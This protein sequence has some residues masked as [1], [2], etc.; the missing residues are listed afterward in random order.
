V[1]KL[2]HMQNKHLG[3]PA[4]VLGG[5]PS[6]LSDM[7]K[8]P[9]GCI[10]FAVNDH[11]FHVGIEPQYMVTMDDPNIKPELKRI[12]DTWRGGLRVNEL[13][14]YSDIDLRGVLRPTARSGI[15]AVWLA[16][17]LGCVPIYLCG[18]DLYQGD[19]KYCHDRDEFMGHKA[20]Y[21]EPLEKL[22]KDWKMLKNYKGW[23][24]IHAVSGPLTQVFTKFVL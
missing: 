14:M 15:F 13:L 18:M 16:L 4:A 11:A 20:I 2:L 17:Y 9:E 5:G 1:D 23:R 7:E 12:V 6:L 19:Q 3:Q 21:N 24:R 22:L 10:L 8:L